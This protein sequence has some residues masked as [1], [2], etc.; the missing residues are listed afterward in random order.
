MKDELRRE[1]LD[2]RQTMSEHSVQ[3]G[4]EGITEK[5][6]SLPC[7]RH[8][9]RLMAYCAVKNEPDMWAFIY[10]LLDMGKRVALPCITGDDI[11]AAEYRRGA[12]LQC[13]AYGIPQPAVSSGCE[14]FE[15]EIVIVPGVVFDLQCC[16]IG[17]GAGYYDRFLRQS[18]AVKIGV[19]YESQLVDNI[20]AEP[21]DVCMDYVV[22]EKRVLGAV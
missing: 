11:V 13:G 18:R 9:L 21:H 12:L 1:M 19:C 17:F 4:S 10:A 20:E 14:S 5:L 22:T 2:M 7:V 6:L 8:A 16:R 15:P 3:R